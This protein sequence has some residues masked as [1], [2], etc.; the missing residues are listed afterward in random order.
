MIA[1]FVENTVFP[2]VTLIA[3]RTVFAF[4]TAAF[5]VSVIAVL[6]NQTP[7]VFGISAQDSAPA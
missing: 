3:T 1:A 2:P 5:A 7:A 4:A 6:L